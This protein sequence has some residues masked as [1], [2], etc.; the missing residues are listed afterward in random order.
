MAPGR[1][2][3]RTAR[4]GGPLTAVLLLAQPDSRGRQHNREDGY[5]N[6]FEG[7]S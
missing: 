1:P 2:R 6:V 7:A 3:R 4:A 5:K